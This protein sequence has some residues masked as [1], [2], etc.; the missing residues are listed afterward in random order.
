VVLVDGAETPTTYLGPTRLG[1]VTPP[2][3][4]GDRITVGVRDTWG[5]TSTIPNAFE[6][7]VSV[8]EIEEPFSDNTME[9]TAFEPTNGGLAQWNPTAVPGKLV[10][11]F[12]SDEINVPDPHSKSVSSNVFP[13][14][15]TSMYVVK[16]YNS[17]DCGNGGTLTGFSFVTGTSTSPGAVFSTFTVLI[18]HNKSSTGLTTSSPRTANFS[19][20]PVTV[21]NGV[22]YTLPKSLSTVTPVPYPTFSKT[23]NYNGKDHIVVDTSQA[24]GTS[25]Q[26][27][28]VYSGYGSETHRVWGYPNTGTTSSGSTTSY[29][30]Q[31]AL[32]F[33]SETSMAQSL[34]YRSESDFTEYLAPTISPTSQPSGTEVLIEYQ[35]AKDRAGVP[36]P[37]TYTAWTEDPTDLRDNRY[38]RFRVTFKANLDTEVGPTLENILIPYLYFD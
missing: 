1:W 19:D 27:W 21:I 16:W 36:D 29:Y 4:P 5:R 25:S 10:A 7:T 18:G 14:N 22:S 35:G 26:S 6:Y 12:G 33:R 23:F 3:S 37:L 20:T 31:C 9:D 38:I 11:T 13:L 2:G 24:G 32:S 17:K 34:F 15:T 28:G 30:Y 8:G